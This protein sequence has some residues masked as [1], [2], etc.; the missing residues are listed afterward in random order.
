MIAE[1]GTLH[2]LQELFIVGDNDELEILLVLSTLDDLV[3]GHSESR[4]VVS[5]KIGCW[6]VESND[7][8]TALAHET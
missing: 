7:L 6:F 3:Q 5:I 1:L 8:E 4:D 2:L